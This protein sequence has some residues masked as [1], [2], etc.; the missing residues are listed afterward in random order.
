[1]D[2]G[3]KGKVALV[4]GGS[5]GLGFAV[6]RAL[7]AEGARVSLLSRNEESVEAAADEIRKESAEA[8]G[9]ALGV[10]GNV[11]S[12][13]DLKRWAAATRDRFGPITLLFAN[14]G[15]PPPGRFPALDDEAWQTGFDSLLLPVI[16][17]AREVIPDMKEAGEG[18]IVI[19]TSSAVKVPLINITVSTVIRGAVS[20]LSRTLAE[21][22][23]DDGI[24]VNQ[25]VPGRIDTDRVKSL[26]EG[27]AKRTGIPVDQQRAQSQ[28]SI[29]VGRY[30]RPEEYG[31]AGAF[32]LSPAASYITGATLQ[33]D[34]GLIRY[35]L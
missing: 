35:V 34:G 32:L 23:A 19:S 8:G 14:T 25:L 20:S 27:A 12:G 30:G 26:D 33:V 1:M 21:E 9:D 11:V 4:G 7:A 3:L 18:S 15:G 6:A 28:A 16:R 22:Y 5:R 17:M 29:P 24:R 13:D 31:R 2:L 10:A